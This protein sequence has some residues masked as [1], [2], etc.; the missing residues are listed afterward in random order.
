MP[1]HPLSRTALSAVLLAASLLTVSLPAAAESMPTYPFVHVAG[2][3]YRE[4]MP[5]IGALDFEIV[6]VDTDPAAAR[7]VLEA[8]VLEARELMKSLDLDPDDVAV[9]EVHQDQ[10]KNRQTQSSS[11]VYELR[12]AVHINVRNLANWPKLAGGLLAK[13]NLDG[14]AATFDLTTMEEVVNELVTQA[15]ADARR[16]AGVI[17]AAEGRR[18]GAMTGATTGELKNLSNSMGLERDAFRYTRSKSGNTRPQGTD[19]EVLM[20]VQILKLSQPVDAIFRLE[21]A[22]PVKRQ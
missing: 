1:K 3:S 6:A 11:P 17:G 10:P 16:R 9:R 18:L 7:A 4:V 21:G 8:R 5:D 19:P 22:A 15:V 20:Q 13:Q 2:S 12:C 14:F